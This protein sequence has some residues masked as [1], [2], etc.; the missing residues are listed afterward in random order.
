METSQFD[1]V[2]GPGRGVRS[3][4]PFVMANDEAE[5][6]SVN[7]ATVQ[8]GANVPPVRRVGEVNLNGEPL[9]ILRQP[10][11]S[12][13]RA[14]ENPPPVVVEIGPN[15]RAFQRLGKR[16][17]GDDLTERPANVG[18]AA[19]HSRITDR[20]VRTNLNRQGQGPGFSLTRL[21]Q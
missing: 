8:K 12:G 5:R 14:T 9:G 16:P 4:V 1:R 10:Q 18:N 20:R 13:A 7:I 17:G 2:N 19:E 11:R 3:F 21:G 15:V 6:H